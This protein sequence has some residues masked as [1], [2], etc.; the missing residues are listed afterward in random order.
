MRRWGRPARSALP[1]VL[2][3]AAGCTVTPLTNKVSPGDDAFVVV[4]G[5][6]DDNATDL[7]AAP[8]GGGSFARFTFNRPV[9]DLP[10]LDPTGTRLAFVR[11][12]ASRD[13]VVSLVVLDLVKNEEQRAAL[14]AGLP[15]PTAL[16]WGRN[17]KVVIVRA[18]TLYQADL[19][20]TLGGIVPV[21]AAERAAADSAV[22]ELLGDPPQ[23][24]ARFCGGQ[25]CIV[26]TGGDS[27]MLG[28]QARDPVRWGP[29]SV[30]YFVGNVLEVRP[31][32]GGRVRRPTWTGTPR[33]ARL[34]T[35]HPGSPHHSGRETG[36]S[37][38]R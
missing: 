2:L 1:A 5:E 20:P 7:F 18:A 27:T 36:L 32:G 34:L 25:A 10:K 23:G 3:A 38:G 37:T 17:G 35:Y 13:S 15:Y 6:G 30:A 33:H 22:E 29:D 4:V 19:T 31:L 11:R 26:A 8:A 16:G 24:V 9:E 21:P 28:N 14:P 12:S